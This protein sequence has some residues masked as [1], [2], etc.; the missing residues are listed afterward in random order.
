MTSQRHHISGNH[1]EIGRQLGDRYAGEIRKIIAAH[2]ELNRKMRPCY[3]TPEGRRR[4]D[5]F[6]DIHRHIYP[7]YVMELQGMADGAGC[8]FRD[9]FM[10]NLRGEYLPF[11]TDDA[12][13]GCSTCS[14]ATPACRLIGHNEDAAALYRDVLFIAD[15]APENGPPFTTLT[16][17]GTLCGNAAGWNS[18][19]IFFTVNI[20]APRHVRIGP[21][22][23]FAA[24]SLLEARSLDDAVARITG[25]RRASGFNYT[26]ASRTDCRIINVEV[27]AGAFHV[28]EIDGAYFHTN[29]YIELPGTDQMI[30]ESSRRRLEHGRAHLARSIPENADALRTLLGDD[31]AIYRRADTP[32]ETA[33]LMTILCDLVSRTVTI[34]TGHPVDEPS[35]QLH[36]RL[37]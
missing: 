5:A 25:P 16:Y 32:E 33:T 24:R 3:S 9:L 2:P 31:S 18:H 4:Y 17:P 12:S 27:T 23:Y 29:H 6:L 21:G 36:F 34:H 11:D 15:I 13:G 14:V 8:D 22:R 1:R 35:R 7:D 26:V 20:T 19:G 28:R 30:T 37:P 10:L